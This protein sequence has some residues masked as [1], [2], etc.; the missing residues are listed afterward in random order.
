MGQFAPAKPSFFFISNIPLA[1]DFRIVVIGVGCGWE[2]RCKN[3][4]LLW[5]KVKVK[6]ASSVNVRNV[7]VHVCVRV[8]TSTHAQ[9]LASIFPCIMSFWV[10]KSAFSSSSEMTS[11]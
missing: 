6:R 10:Y 2:R 3:K 11:L 9:T 4:L 8:Y 7:Y 1:Q 5:E